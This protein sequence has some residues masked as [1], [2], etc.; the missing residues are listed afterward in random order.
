MHSAHCTRAHN[1]KIP[2]V[3]AFGYAPGARSRTAIL[4]IHVSY[5]CRQK[6]QALHLYR[7]WCSA[8]WRCLTHEPCSV[9]CEFNSVE[10]LL[11][12]CTRTVHPAIGDD[13]ENEN[14]TKIVNAFVCQ[15]TRV[16]K[17][18]IGWCDWKTELSL[19]E[20]M[21]GNVS[22]KCCWH[23][24]P[25]TTRS[26][27]CTKTTFFSWKMKNRNIAFRTV[28]YWTHNEVYERPL[29]AT[30]S[31]TLNRIFKLFIIITCTMD[32]A[33]TNND[34]DVN[35]AWMDIPITVKAWMTKYVLWIKCDAWKDGKQHRLKSIGRSSDAGSSNE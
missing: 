11:E 23:L 27:V 6:W 8:A 3:N 18:Q 5:E 24:S 2:S 34:S 29:S 14:V 22:R 4:I 9:P 7:I 25:A 1:T 12:S 17:M 28:W 15:C 32:D 10:Y 19:C 35:P 21:K 26:H 30:M 16:H 20:R 13:D 33:P 31:L